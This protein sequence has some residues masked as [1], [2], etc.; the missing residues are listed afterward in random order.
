MGMVFYLRFDEENGSKAGLGKSFLYNLCID[1]TKQL[2]SVL[3]N[4][5]IEYLKSIYV[6]REPEGLI[7]MESEKLLNIFLKLKSSLLSKDKLSFYMIKEIDSADIGNDITNKSG[8]SLS[9][10]AHFVYKDE[11]FIISGDWNFC[12][13]SPKKD[14]DDEKF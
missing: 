4:E 11:E 10:L 3:S 1:L 2:K 13:L 5:D 9:N 12:I 6:P 7:E 14:Y 8:F